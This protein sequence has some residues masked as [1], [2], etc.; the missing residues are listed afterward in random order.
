MTDL[1][2]ILLYSKLLT[3][4]Y[5]LD[6]KVLVAENSSPG[7]VC[8]GRETIETKP[9]QTHACD[10]VHAELLAVHP[11]CRHAGGCCDS[12]KRLSHLA[13]VHCHP[14]TTNL[15]FSFSPQRAEKKAMTKEPLVFLPAL[16]ELQERKGGYVA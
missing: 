1:Y 9:G 6:T 16:K 10:T 7:S 12:S 4:E 11:G 5:W 8:K 13:A 14:L 3:P 15:F 2:N